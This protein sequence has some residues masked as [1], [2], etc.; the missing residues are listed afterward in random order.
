MDTQQN[1]P[2]LHLH[3]HFLLRFRFTGSTRRNRQGKMQQCYIFVPVEERN[4]LRL[5]E[6]A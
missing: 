6:S 5:G 3:G 2:T 1:E 4:A